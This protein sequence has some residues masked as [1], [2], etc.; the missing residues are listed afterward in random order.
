VWELAALA[1]DACQTVFGRDW[2]VVYT[3]A[4]GAAITIT[5]IS[6]DEQHE[7]VMEEGPTAF[8]TR[9]PVLDVQLADFATDPKQNDTCVISATGYTATTFQVDDIQPDGHGAAKLLLTKVG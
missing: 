1:Q 2:T 7:V 6:F 5:P 3:P 8:S 4:G 9:M